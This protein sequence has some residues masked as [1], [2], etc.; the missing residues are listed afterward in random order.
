MPGGAG[1]VV[2]VVDGVVVVGCSV[3]GGA[4]GAVVVGAGV[5][6]VVVVEDAGGADVSPGRG[7]AVDVVDVGVAVVVEGVPTTVVGDV[8]V[9]VAGGG[10]VVVVVVGD[11][12]PSPKVNASEAT[13]TVAA[14]ERRLTSTVP[15]TV[16]YGSGTS[17]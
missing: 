2:V 15:G 6:W 8:G 10:A 1:A 4:P 17:R 7:A 14:P 12:V 9:D 13:S 3:G 11:V 16:T 5:G